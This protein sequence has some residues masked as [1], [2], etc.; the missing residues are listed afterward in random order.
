MNHKL[1]AKE[2]RIVAQIMAA[3]E[4]TK[5]LTTVTGALGLS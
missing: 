2:K 5:M 3:S 4:T 1:Y